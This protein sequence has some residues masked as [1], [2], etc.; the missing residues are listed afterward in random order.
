[1]RDV[2]P[3]PE[4]TLS[5]MVEVGAEDIHFLDNIVKSHDHLAQV[6]RDYRLFQGRPCYEI[7]VP[8]QRL[9]ELLQVLEHLKKL[10]WI[11][12]VAVAPA[13]KRG[14]AEGDAPLDAG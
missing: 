3:P 8:P 2:P 1:M 9:E 5:L 4:D 6:R 7:M 14:E 10:I 12:H 13:S 11:G